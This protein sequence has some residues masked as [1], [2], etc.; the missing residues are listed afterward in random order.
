MFG[1]GIIFIAVFALFDFLFLR[2]DC[3]SAHA[4]LV[5]VTAA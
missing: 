4:Q 2:L 3:W 5:S 1:G